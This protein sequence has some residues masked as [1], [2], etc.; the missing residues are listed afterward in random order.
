MNWNPIIMAHDNHP[1]KTL[2]IKRI[3]N[4]FKVKTT[5]NLAYH[6]CNQWRLRLFVTISNPHCV[7]INTW[8]RPNLF[9]ASIQLFTKQ[10]DLGRPK[11]FI[12][13][14]E[15][16]SV[17][18]FEPTWNISVFYWL[19]EAAMDR[20]SVVL[21]QSTDFVYFYLFIESFVQNH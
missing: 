16:N 6:E 14:W 1:Y 11:V 10:T 2:S 3:H 12:N 15:G 7:R 17:W 21:E 13:C 20:D 18:H 19:V 9:Q 8:C 4:G 5:F